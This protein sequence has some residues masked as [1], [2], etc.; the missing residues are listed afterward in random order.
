MCEGR[1]RGR[2][3]G[4]GEGG[5]GR[6]GRHNPHGIVKGGACNCL[7]Y[8]HFLLNVVKFLACILFRSL[9]LF[10]HLLQMSWPQERNTS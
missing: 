2:E 8:L 3:R 4:G 9:S 6:R 7:T 1:E 10:H 5:R